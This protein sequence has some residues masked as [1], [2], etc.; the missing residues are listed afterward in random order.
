MPQRRYTQAQ[1]I[2]ALKQAE[3]FVTVAA[4]ALGC[5]A[6]TIYN[7]RD[8]YPSVRAVM[9]E[10]R[11]KIKDLAEIAMV[12]AIQAQQGWAVTLC[13]TTLARDRGYVS[14][15]DV[16]LEIQH[17][18]AKVAEEF[19]MTAEEVLAEAESYLAEERR[20]R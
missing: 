11:E 8:K 5:S 20:A 15:M 17:T 13:L 2:R 16:R 18:A 4:E 19:G 7:F 12:Q 9:Q 1:I 10:Q 3:G 14:R 6:Q